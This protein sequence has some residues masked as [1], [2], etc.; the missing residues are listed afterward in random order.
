MTTIEEEQICIKIALCYKVVLF[1][2]KSS[3]SSCYQ[4]LIIQLNQHITNR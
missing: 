4:R 3:H 2:G 1:Q